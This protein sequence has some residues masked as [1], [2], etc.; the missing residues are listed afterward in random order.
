MTGVFA[1]PPGIDRVRDVHLYPYQAD[2]VAFLVSK[3]RAILGDDMGAGQNAPG[4][5]RDGKRGA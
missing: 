5:R 1:L 3:K 4:H 2:G